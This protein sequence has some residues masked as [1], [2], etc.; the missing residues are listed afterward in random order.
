M[1]RT[2]EGTIHNISDIDQLEQLFSDFCSAKRFAY[3]RFKNGISLNDVRALTKSKYPRLNTRYVYDAVSEG[4]ALFKRFGDKKIIFG[5]RKLWN[6]RLKNEISNRQWKE[7]RNDSIYSRGEANKSGNLNTRL[8][9]TNDGI[10]LRINTGEA[11]HYITADLWFPKKYLYIIMDMLTSDKPCYSIRIKREPKQIRI[12]I[13]ID[14]SI[15]KAVFTL[16]N[17]A[18]GID[19]NPNQIAIAHV[20]INGNLVESKTIENNRISFAKQGKRD[21]DIW[22]IAK[23]IVDFAIQKRCGIVVEN[24]K[25]KREAKDRVRNRIFNNFVW[26]KLLIAI[27]TKALRAGVEV[28]KVNPAFTSVVGRLKYCNQIT[29]HESAAYVIGRRGLNFEERVPDWL[30]S[31]LAET[32]REAGEKKSSWRVWSLLKKLTVPDRKAF[33]PKR[34]K[35]RAIGSPSGLSPGLL[36]YLGQD[37]PL[38]AFKQS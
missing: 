21:Y 31:I 37:A 33:Y 30:R 6:Q 11:R 4:N 3:N 36:G 8:I 34:V 38:G 29:I 13:S 15:P 18:I 19:L 1:Q 17:G 27:E 25:F 16:S 26:K 5:S 35:R 22:Q 28:R 20:D 14:E 9:I 23:E 7:S 10:K 2:I 24:L 12:M 32:L